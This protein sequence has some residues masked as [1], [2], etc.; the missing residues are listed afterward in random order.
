VTQC[1][2]HPQTEAVA[3]CVSCGRGVCEVCSVRIN[4]APHCKEC[5]EA[6][7]IKGGMPK[8]Q[9]PPTMPLPGMPPAYPYPMMRPQDIYF[10]PRPTG[11]PSP[12]LFK[13]GAVGAMIAAISCILIG[14]YS[15]MGLSQFFKAPWLIMIIAGHIPFF[16]LLPAYLGLGRNYSVPSAMT[17]FGVLLIMLTTSLAIWVFILGNL[18][19]SL[20]NY[21]F[22]PVFAVPPILGTGFIV[23]SGPLTAAAKFFPPNHVSRKSMDKAGPLMLVTG[24]LFLLYAG[25]MIIGWITLMLSLIFLSIA[26]LNAPIPEIQRPPQPAHPGPPPGWGRQGP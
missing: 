2:V 11:T 21:I 24:I 7:R 18:T 10:P 23:A 4:D 5:V 22:I 3:C 14:A 17:R 26:L 13:A 16:G 12:G 6:G 1:G 25:F 9:G 20:R 15:V 19:S 8:P